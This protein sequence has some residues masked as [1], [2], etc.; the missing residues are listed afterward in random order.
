MNK[1]ERGRMVA[2]M[3]G[4]YAEILNRNPDYKSRDHVVYIARPS[5]DIWNS[6]EKKHM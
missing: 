2:F 1:T 4:V 6:E 3:K 5:Q